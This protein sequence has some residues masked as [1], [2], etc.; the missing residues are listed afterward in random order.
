M[1]DKMYKDELQ[2]Q[3]WYGEV[4]DIEDP[5]KIGRVRIKVFG[6]FDN[7]PNGMLPWAR[8]KFLITPGDD[9]GAGFHNPPKLNSIVAVEFENGNIY[10]PFYMYQDRISDGLKDEIEN[11][12]EGAL[13]LWYDEEENVKLYHV[14]EKGIMIEYNDTLINLNKDGTI[15][16]NVEGDDRI[17]HVKPNMI[18][19]GQLD[20]SAEPATLGD[21]NVDA[22][23]E[24]ANQIQT[25]ATA[26]STFSTT[27][28]TIA[29]AISVYSPLLAGWEQVTPVMTNVLSQNAKTKATTIPA[30]KSRKTSLD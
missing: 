22:L 25:I 8:P 14:R 18:S 6:K 24:L 17:L 30:T 28:A 15:I 10:E 7:I 23:N 29:K 16:L 3:I 20:K 12:Y 27:Q 13:S 11:D 21:K 26:L 2:G 19:L 5:Q 1:D 9:T 4:V